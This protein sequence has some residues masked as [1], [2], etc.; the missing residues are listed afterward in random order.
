MEQNK[1]MSSYTK[2][3]KQA[4]IRD[5]F[6]CVE[7]GKETGLEVHHIKPE[8]E[9]LDNLITLC[10][11]CHKKRHNM[12]GCFKRGNDERRVETMFKK[13]ECTP[14]NCFRK[15]IYYNRWLGKWIGK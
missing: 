14:K 2:L 13:G 5:G 7:C 10:H 11:S 8:I 4:N 12:A 3:D 6:K 15:G 9:E 1:Y